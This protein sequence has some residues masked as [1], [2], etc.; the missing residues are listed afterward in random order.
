VQTCLLIGDAD[1]AAA[2]ALAGVRGTTPESAAEA[3]EAFRSAVAE[4]EIMM[5][6]VTEGFALQLEEEIGRHRQKGARPMVIEIP[7]NLSGEFSSRSLME[8]IRNAVGIS[9]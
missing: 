3:K 6:I 2:F 7:E 4:P 9:V 8:A 5:L 1:S